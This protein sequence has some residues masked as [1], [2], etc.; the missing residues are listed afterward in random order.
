MLFNFFKNHKVTFSEHFQY[1]LVMFSLIL[2]MKNTTKAYELL[3]H[4]MVPNWL[5]FEV[6]PISNIP[7]MFNLGFINET[8][9]YHLYTVPGPKIC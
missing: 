5:F 8:I 4:C 9:L 1:V 7:R 6:E 3:L 2:P